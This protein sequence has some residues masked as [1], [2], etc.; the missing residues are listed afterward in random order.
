[1][2]L[3]PLLALAAVAVVALLHVWIFVLESFLWTKRVGRRVFGTTVEQA[4]TT[5]VLA[6]NQGFYNLFLAAGLVW[7]IVAERCAFEIKVFFLVCVIVAGIVGG[8]TAK[9]S[10]LIVQALP[11]LI[12]LLLVFFTMR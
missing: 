4:E 9:R 11:A 10:I 2:S 12:A 6:L 5:K 8:I 7:G 1:M 3:Y